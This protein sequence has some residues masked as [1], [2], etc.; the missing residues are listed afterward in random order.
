MQPKK[1]QIEKLCGRARR[2][3]R[4]IENGY[5]PQPKEPLINYRQFIAMDDYAR[6]NSLFG[7][8]L[9]CNLLLKG[10]KGY[11][12]IRPSLF[13]KRPSCARK[14]VEIGADAQRKQ[15]VRILE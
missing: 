5:S 11:P 3:R 2:K 1:K 6:E 13:F 10:P 15:S 12:R 7:V 8:E 9:P 14:Y 4:I